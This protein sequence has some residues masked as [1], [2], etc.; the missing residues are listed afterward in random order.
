MARL[1]EK[2]R[3]AIL[4]CLIALGFG[5]PDAEHLLWAPS[6]LRDL[7]ARIPSAARPRDRLVAALIELDQLPATDGRDPLMAFLRHAFSLRPP[8]DPTVKRLAEL[9]RAV[10]RRR[11]L[12]LIRR[13]G[14][15]R[16]RG[17]ELTV[18]LERQGDQVQVSWHVGGRTLGLAP[19]RYPARH[20]DEPPPEALMYALFPPLADG[21][22]PEPEPVMLALGPSPS[23][24]GYH[25][26]LRICADDPAWARLPWRELRW[27]GERLVDGQSPWTIELVGQVE[28]A[29]DV[30]LARVPDVVV[31][32]ADDGALTAD[33]VRQSLVIASRTYARPNHVVGTERLDALP[34][35]LGS[36]R[37][38][39]VVAALDADQRAR[40]GGLL[41]VD[42]SARHAPA[43]LCLVGGPTTPPA[44][45]LARAPV[46]VRVPDAD[47]AKAWLRRVLLEDTD[48]VIAAHDG[49]RLDSTRREAHPICTAYAGW[50]PG[51]VRRD[52]PP[53]PG[54]VLDRIAQRNR[55]MD[56]LRLLMGPEAHHHMVVFVAS[57]PR[58]NCIHL[59]SEQLEEHIA[60]LRPSLHLEVWRPTLP[61]AGTYDIHAASAFHTAAVAQC[62]QADVG[63]ATAGLARHLT[64]GHLRGTERIVWL[65]WGAFGYD[66]PCQRRLKPSELRAWLDWHVQFADSAR[67]AGVRVA[68]F[69]ACET[70]TSRAIDAIKAEVTA[71]VLKTDLTS[72][73]FATLGPLNAVGIDELRT[74]LNSPEDSRVQPEQVGRLTRALHD[75][76]PD[77]HFE[78]LVEQL[79]LGLRIGWQDL[80]TRLEQSASD[81]DDDEEFE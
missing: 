14:P 49:D 41:R 57:G 10:D 7:R 67:A 78:R 48:P 80:L 18:Q 59:L 52:E 13:L 25:A 37:R 24:L 28:P 71:A 35:L 8:E 9:I 39:V 64:H 40:L 53:P 74:Y 12:A 68:A 81:D 69:I 27:H 1:D 21:R 5:A 62:M 17:K 42:A 66:A 47:A 38:A 30:A 16:L 50:R 2:R 26:R 19:R 45:L 44:A 23:P 77:G 63:H 4:E 56:R 6:A 46:V 32:D 72:I 79:E 15:H 73:D 33:G 34:R 22:P 31:L 61:R 29:F 75:A 65:D 76:V 55:V 3:G 43:A 36:R 70:K 60:K 54:L 58:E 51:R 20:L 11:D